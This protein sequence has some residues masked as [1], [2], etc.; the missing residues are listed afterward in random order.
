METLIVEWI[1]RSFSIVSIEGW[2]DHLKEQQPKPQFQTGGETLG[3]D[4]QRAN[5]GTPL[6]EKRIN[7]EVATKDF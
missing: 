6:K 2:I 4:S 5:L 1:E 7:R 3:N